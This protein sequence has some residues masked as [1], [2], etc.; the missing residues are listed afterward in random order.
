MKFLYLPYQRWDAMYDGLPEVLA[1]PV[2]IGGNLL[3]CDLTDGAEQYRVV[4]GLESEVGL[5]EQRLLR[6]AFDTMADSPLGTG[7]FAQRMA[8]ELIDEGKLIPQRPATSSYGGNNR[9][10]A[11]PAVATDCT[12]KEFLHS[13]RHDEEPRPKSNNKSKSR[14]PAKKKRKR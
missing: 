8:K 12:G 7:V 3:A 11:L 5:V 6:N 1:R 10:S 4:R 2:V 14:T 13:A 9:R